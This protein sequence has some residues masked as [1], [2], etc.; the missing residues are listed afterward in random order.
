MEDD[1]FIPPIGSLPDS[2]TGGGSRAAEDEDD[3]FVP[4]TGE[5]PKHRT[6]GGSRLVRWLRIGAAIGASAW[7]ASQIT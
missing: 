3:D 5:P 2:R 1:D 4:R 7:A 6:G